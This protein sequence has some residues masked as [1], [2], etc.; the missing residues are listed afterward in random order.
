MILVIYF[1]G[2]I[3]PGESVFYTRLFICLFSVSYQVLFEKVQ[4]VLKI[5]KHADLLNYVSN[6]RCSNVSKKVPK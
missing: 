3:K 4:N 6:K 1:H 2:A 5:L